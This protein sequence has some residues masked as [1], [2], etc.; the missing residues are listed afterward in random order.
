LKLKVYARHDVDSPS[1]DSASYSVTRLQISPLL[2]I[3]GLH[4]RNPPE[5][6]G[7]PLPCLDLFDFSAEARDTMTSKHA[8]VRESPR[9][10][11]KERS[12]M[13]QGGWS[14]GYRIA[15]ASGILS[16]LIPSGLGAFLGC[17]S[18]A[19]PAERE[20]ADSL[21]L[22]STSLREGQFPASFTCNGANTSPA[23]AWNAPPANTQSLA[24]ILNDRDAPLGSFVHW[25]L[26]ELPATTRALPEAVP[27]QEQ[28]ADGSR[29]GRNDFGEIGYG[30]PCPPGHARHRYVFLLFALDTKLNLPAGSSRNEVEAATN[31]HVLAR[32]T[33]TASFSR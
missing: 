21:A 22:S 15:S 20:G 13:R 10:G 25:V 16:L 2:H 33:L 9:A 8:R 27:T 14:R 1:N 7:E 23:L 28:L 12:A 18:S 3:M 19:L 31:G 5:R 11:A 30:G 6:P 17:R 32:G 26:F 24:L 29:Q 4:Q